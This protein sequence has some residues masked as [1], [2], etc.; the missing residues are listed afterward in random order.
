MG[1]REGDKG[2]FRT[3][4]V[5]YRRIGAAAPTV[6]IGNGS[7]ICTGNVRYRITGTLENRRPLNSSTVIGQERRDGGGGNAGAGMGYSASE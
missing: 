7:T 2:Y 6:N 3:Y 1:G 4:V 5:S